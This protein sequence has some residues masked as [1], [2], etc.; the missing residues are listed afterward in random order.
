MNDEKTAV[1]IT[2]IIINMWYYV[3]DTL[4]ASLCQSV[5][6]H[7]LPEFKC[8]LCLIV[9]RESVMFHSLPEF[10]CGLCLIV[11]GCQSVTFHSL[12]EFKC[13]LC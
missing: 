8:G 1:L 2:M 4:I 11:S 12:P 7:S 13:G 6:F 3:G 10:K 5:M 9:S